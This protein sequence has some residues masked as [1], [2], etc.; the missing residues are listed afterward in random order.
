V[1]HGHKALLRLFAAA[2]VLVSLAAFGGARAA[3]TQATLES[4]ATG[5]DNPR[6]LSF[7]PD[8]ALYVAEAGTGG[9]EADGNCRVGPE[10]GE[11]YGAT[12]SITKITFGTSTISQ[13]RVLTRLPSLAGEG[14]IGATGPHDVSVLSNGDLYTVVGYGGLPISRTEELGP[15]GADFGQLVV[16]PGNYALPLNDADIAAYEQE[17]NPDGGLVDSNPYSVVALRDWRVVVDAGGNSLLGVLPDDTVLTLATFP[18]RTVSAP[19]GI[20]NLPEGTPIPMDSV[21]TAVA[22]GPDG[23]YYVGELTGFPAPVGA[24]RVYRVVPGQEPTVYAEG[25]TAIIDLAFDA[26][27]NLYVLEFA[28]E[29][30]LQATAPTGD[31]TGEL[32]TVPFTDTVTLPEPTVTEALTGTTVISTGLVL[33][34]GVA[35]GPEGGIYIS[36]S[37]VFS[38]TGEVVRVDTCEGDP[39]CTEPVALEAPYTTLAN[40]AEEVNAQGEPNQGDPDG[41]GPAIFTFDA[42]AGTVC[43]QSLVANID[44][45]TLAH[46]HRGPEGTNGSVVINFTPFI[47]GQT[48]SGCVDDVDTAL[49]EEIE[50]EPENFYFNVHNAAYPNGAVRGQ[51]AAGNTAESEVA[52][53]ITFRPTP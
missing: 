2:S 39:S 4:I 52:L 5:L 47:N 41:I 40:G 43:V 46:I 38:G 35:V 9:P 6:G 10:G 8:G 50:A 27:G 36:N 30:W 23:A 21:P 31:P 34:T 26:D 24:A 16:R 17:S 29:G 20:P 15:A 3:T 25:F 49:I 45:P 19:P 44:Q 11:C 48:I 28:R 42:A 32:L 22:I 18:T 13:T 14:G 1:L 33:P 12:G 37:G 7:G 51:L 53:P